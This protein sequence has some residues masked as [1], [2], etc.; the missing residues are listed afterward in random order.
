M[1]IVQ[2]TMRQG[3]SYLL[4]TLRTID[5]SGPGA[6]VIVSD[7]P[8]SDATHHEGWE[9]IELPWAGARATG[10][11]CMRLAILRGEDLTL[12]QDDI[13]VCIGGTDL[14]NRTIVPDNCIAVSF[15]SGSALPG[16][17]PKNH[18]EPRFI[19]MGASGTAQALKIPR[20]SL[21]FLCAQ[22]PQ[23]APHVQLQPHLFDD[24]MFSY[25][26]QSDWPHIAHLVP[27]PVRHVGSVSACGTRR[28]FRQEWA[29]APG[30][31]FPADVTTLP[32]YEVL[33]RGVK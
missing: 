17:Q 4:E 20:R 1:I 22:D 30:E 32:R 19:I 10:W 26:R 12:L 16:L 9:T 15:Y 21:E 14:M 6:H 2:T 29:V 7:G 3:A 25:A 8:L 24:A 33:Y 28:P 23:Q 5:T 27:N 31:T 11:E 13:E 18:G